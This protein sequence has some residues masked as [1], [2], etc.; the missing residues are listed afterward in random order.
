MWQC[1][2]VVTGWLL[3]LHGPVEGQGVDA[4]WW[5]EEKLS[6]N[7]SQL[8]AASNANEVLLCVLDLKPGLHSF[9]FQFALVH[10]CVN[11]SVVP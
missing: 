11:H 9:S 7:R 10:V 3:K 6:L 8:V 2:H 4:L 1:L 5:S